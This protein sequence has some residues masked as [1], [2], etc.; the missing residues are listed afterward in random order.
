MRRVFKNLARRVL[1]SGGKEWSCM[2]APEYRAEVVDW[3]PTTQHIGDIISHIFWDIPDSEHS[4][5]LGPYILSFCLEISSAL[6]AMN[7]T[8]QQPLLASHIPHLHC[9]S[10]S[11][12]LLIQGPLLGMLAPPLCPS[13]SFS[14]F[15]NISSKKVLLIFSYPRL[16][17]DLLH[18]VIVSCAYFFHWT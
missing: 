1:F 15:F 4:T 10:T 17:W 6:H 8:L 5:S 7:F 3:A 9:G 16:G 14:P 12:P 11:L 13:T 2:S 18:V